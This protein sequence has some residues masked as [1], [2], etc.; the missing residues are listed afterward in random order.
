MSEIAGSRSSSSSGPSPKE[1]VE[2]VGDQLLALAQL[3]GVVLDSS[4]SMERSGR[5][6]RLRDLALDGREAIEIERLSRSVW[7]R[8][9]IS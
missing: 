7:M 5:N 6:L 4:S 8:L 2:D 1:L 3:S 9:L